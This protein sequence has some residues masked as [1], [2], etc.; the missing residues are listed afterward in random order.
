MSKIRKK[1]ILIPEDVELKIENNSLKIKGP[2]GEIQRKIPQ[3]IRLEIKENKLFVLPLASRE[4]HPSGRD[5]SFEALSPKI[6]SLFG[7]YYRIFKNDITGVISGFEKKLEIQ[8][9]GFR[10]QL[11]NNGD[12]VLKVGFS[13]P[14][15]VKKEEGVSFS[16]EKNIIKVCGIEKEKVGNLAAKIRRVK[17]P[18]S[19]KGKGIRYLGERVRKKEGKKVVT[20]SGT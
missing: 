10:A 18:E 11:N 8:G 9:I 17:P 1:P 7:L 5:R 15:V 14:V 19:Y 20:V 3:E 12:L 16:V 2:K 6:K 4:I 13:H